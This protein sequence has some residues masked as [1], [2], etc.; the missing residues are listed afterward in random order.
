M[1]LPVPALSLIAALALSPAPVLGQMQNAALSSST[2]TFERS[3]PDSGRIAFRVVREEADI[4]SHELRFRREGDRLLV[5]VTI[6]LK[7]TFLGVPLYRYSHR[8]SEAW[9][10]GRL[11]ALRT[12]TDNN[13]TASAVE[14]RATEGGFLVKA[15]GKETLMPANTYP[16]S[17]WNRAWLEGQPLLNTQTG[18]R[19]DFKATASGSETVETAK[20]PLSA[21]RFAITGDLRKEIWFDAAG[22]WV[23]TSFAAPDGSV[24]SYVLQ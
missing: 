19:I 4:G 10:Q 22:R 7:V 15:G 12:T 13:G 18:E 17:H 23:K 5:D 9:E 24:I 21:Q 14:G 1:R 16:S 3:I 6:D 11:V 20:G 2:A 8:A